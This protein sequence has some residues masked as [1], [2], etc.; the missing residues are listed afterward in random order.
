MPAWVLIT[1]PL[2]VPVGATESVSAWAVV[3]HAVLE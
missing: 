3:P 2:P 1:T